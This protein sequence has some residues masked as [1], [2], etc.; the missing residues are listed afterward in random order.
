[1]R[2]RSRL[3]RAIRRMSWHAKLPAVR[4]V[5]YALFPIDL[6]PYSYRCC[7]NVDDMILVPL[8][9]AMAVWIEHE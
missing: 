6:I 4:V 2:M 7:D 1:M 9:V 5:A 3:Q 8:G